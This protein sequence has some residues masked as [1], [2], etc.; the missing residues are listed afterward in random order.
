MGTA[1]IRLADADLLPF[2]FTNLADTV[3]TLHQASCRRC[4]KQRQD[5][6]RER[7]RQIE[8]GVFAAVDDPR[9][10][11]MAPETKDVPPAM[12]FAPLEN[13]ATALTRAAD[14]YQE[15]VRTRR[16]RRCRAPGRRQ[17]RQRAADSERARADRPRRAARRARGTA[18]CSMRQAPT[19]ATP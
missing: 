17:G 4:C 19:P 8:D 12:N 1:V 16:G 13:A 9:R 7:N 14:R 18:T 3:Q 15:G 10:P 6:V 11:S 2:E 5:E